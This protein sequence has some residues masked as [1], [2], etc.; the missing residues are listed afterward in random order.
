[1]RA[2]V[3]WSWLEQEIAIKS[4]KWYALEVYV[5]SDIAL[6]EKDYQNTI[7]SLGCIGRWRKVITSDYG[8]INAISSWQLKKGYL[9]L[10]IKKG[11]NLC[12]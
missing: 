2:T 12:S 11:I 6:S 5:K 9:F 3:S 7:F 1:M 10:A 8:I 4:G